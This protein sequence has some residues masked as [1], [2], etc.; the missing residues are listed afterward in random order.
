MVMMV[1]VMVMVVYFHHDLRL[2]CVWHCKR[3][4]E[5]KGENG[6]NQKLFHTHMMTRFVLL[7]RATLTNPR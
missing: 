4:C 2:R 5:A 6:S 3:Y 1:V 7:Y